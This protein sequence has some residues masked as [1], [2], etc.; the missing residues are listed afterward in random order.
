MTVSLT[1]FV[2]P[3]ATAL[4][5]TWLTAE[6]SAVVTV[7]LAGTDAAGFVFVSGTVNPPAGAF[8]RAPLAQISQICFDP[9]ARFEIHPATVSQT[10]EFTESWV[11]PMP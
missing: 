3:P 2:T 6:T 5:V 10:Y 7:T 11:A 1:V 8:R 9:G 4:I